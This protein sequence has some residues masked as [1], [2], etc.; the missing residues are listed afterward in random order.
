MDQNIW[1]LS[2]VLCALVFLNVV[3]FYF[4][5]KCTM[6]H[7]SPSTLCAAGHAVILDLVYL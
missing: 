4:L 5:C 7:G 6:T 3:W 2:E 1:I